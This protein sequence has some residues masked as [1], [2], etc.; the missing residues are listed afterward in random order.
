VAL[1]ATKLTPTFIDYRANSILY[2]GL[3][4]LEEKSH[5]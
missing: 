3:Q 2:S 1:P 5:C 4:T